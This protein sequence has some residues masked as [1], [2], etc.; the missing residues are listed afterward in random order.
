M[1]SNSE[2]NH[3]HPLLRIP[4]NIQNQILPDP[5]L[6]ILEF[7]K[8]KLPIVT[9]T[10]ATYL[11]S[12]FFSKKPPTTPS[13][14]TIQNIPVPP[15]QIVAELGKSCQA[16]MLDG[17]LSVV[18]THTSLASK[19]HLP[20][21]IILYWTEVLSLRC[22]HREPW[23][24]AKE[25]LRRMTI[26]RGNNP[27]ANRQ[28]VDTVYNAL[29]SLAWS[30]DI[31]GF[32]A[33]EPIYQL[34]H[35]LSRRWFSNVHEDQMVDL[36]RRSIRLNQSTSGHFEIES[37]AFYDKIKD[38]YQQQTKVSEGQAFRRLRETGQALNSGTRDAIGFLTN[39]GNHWVAIALDFSNSRILYGD[40]FKN[41][42]KKSMIDTLNWWTHHLSGRAF[43]HG[44]LDISLQPMSDT[45]SCGLLAPNSLAH[46]FL[47]D[48]YPL[49]DP[50]NVDNE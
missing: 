39:I 24:L 9:K 41:P 35:Y 6:S 11:S 32:D 17:N 47:S 14:E 22:K 38:A 44:N 10:K 25:H 33:K 28:L 5:A 8:F 30:G 7:L 20:L 15:P 27:A 36:L 50:K 19:L 43:S 2:T 40:P 26:W 29:S 21:W 31:Q 3:I 48:Q 12:T 13:A 49:I 4:H 34:A 46:H 37:L 1:E 42:P 16:E 45:F 23:V 18:C